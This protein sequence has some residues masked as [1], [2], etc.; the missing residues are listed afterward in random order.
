MTL[1]I[2]LA[3]PVALRIVAPP[4]F[5]L[6]SLL[7]VV[8]LVAL[9]A[10]PIA[11]SG[12][13][14]RALITM[15]RAK[16]LAAAAGVAAAFNIA[17]NLVLVPVIGITGAAA[18]TVA[19]FTLQAFLQLRALPKHRKWPVPPTSLVVSVLAACVLSAGSVLIPQTA[20]L[21]AVRLII[22]CA[23][24][25][26]LLVRLRTAR[27]G[28]DRREPEIGAAVNGVPQPMR[29]VVI[30]LD[31]PLP[32]LAADEHYARAW[33]VGLRHGVPRGAIEVD[34]TG[35]REGNPGPAGPAA[36]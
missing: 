11:A 12:A 25:P 29:V 7:I 26:W 6:P 5:G 33:V 13:S 9:S 30:D 36:R 14:G 32:E 18:A 23:C 10:F 2:T 35:A 24:L 19:A 28:R 27:G 3:A 31:D 20:L 21:N 22:A 34:L 15:R 8:Y 17:L 16:P 4:T 1:G